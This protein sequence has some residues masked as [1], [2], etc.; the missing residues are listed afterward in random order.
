[1]ASRHFYQVSPS[2]ALISLQLHMEQIEMTSWRED[3]LRI[4]RE[5]V[6]KLSACK[7]FFLNKRQ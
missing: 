1:M 7:I 2:V 6:Q 3:Q 4:L 5:P